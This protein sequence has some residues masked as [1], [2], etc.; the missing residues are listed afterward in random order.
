MKFELRRN[1]FLHR[2]CNFC[3]RVQPCFWLK[4]DLIFISFEMILKFFLY[5]VKC[6]SD[7]AE[8]QQSGGGRSAAQLAHLVKTISHLSNIRLPISKLG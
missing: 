2:Y 7:L 1:K 4:K 3:L 5:R 8:L 6:L